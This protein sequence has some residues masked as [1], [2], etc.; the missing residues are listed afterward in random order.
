MAAMGGAAAGQAAFFAEE[1]GLVQT[2]EFDYEQMIS[3][4][5]QKAWASFI[6]LPPSWLGTVCCVPCFIND[7]VE[8]DNRA[9]HVA[10]T[11][12]GIKFVHDKRKALCGLYCTD[13]GKVS[14]TVPYDKITD[15]DVQEPAGMACCCCIENV[16]HTVTV[17]TASSGGSD[18]KGL[19]KHELELSGLQRPQE[20]KHAVWAMKRG[21]APAGV[22]ASVAEMLARRAQRVPP[23]MSGAGAAPQQMDMNTALLSDIKH[24]LEKLTRNMESKCG[25]V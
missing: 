18:Q 3:F 1:P 4:Y 17:D 6:C 8:W 10:L 22:S 19:M 7:N 12:D 9:K 20:F 23:P 15:C 25:A 5:Q 16:L 24:E 21:E 14:K 13:Q 2:F 11:I